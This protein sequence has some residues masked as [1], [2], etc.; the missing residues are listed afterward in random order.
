MLSRT[1]RHLEKYFGLRGARVM[2]EAFFSLFFDENA[3]SAAEN[4]SGIAQIAHNFNESNL[5][6]F[7]VVRLTEHLNP[8]VLRL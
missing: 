5:S 4:P 1:E 7:H 2:S 6:L 3:K 8:I